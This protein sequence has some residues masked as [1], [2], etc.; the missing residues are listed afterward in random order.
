MDISS[1][2][3]GGH[4]RLLNSPASTPIFV[5]EPTSPTKSVHLE[6]MKDQNTGLLALCLR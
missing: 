5:E 3:K 1:I 2:D 4:A 6:T